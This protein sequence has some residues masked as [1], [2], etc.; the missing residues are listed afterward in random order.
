MLRMIMFGKPGAGKGTLSA[1]LVKKY[2]I[3]SIST[4]DLLRQHIAHKTDIGKQAEEIV[5][6]GDLLPD[7]LVLR[8]VTSKLDHLQDKHWILD[9]FPRTIGQGELL[10]AHLRLA[11]TPLTLLAT[12][13]VPLPF[14]RA[15]IAGRFVHAAS[16]RVYNLDFNPPRLAG[17]D[18]LT[19]EPLVQR[20]DD[21]PEVYERRLQAYER[22]TAPLLGYYTARAAS[23]SAGGMGGAGLRVVSFAGETSDEMWPALEQ[24]V[25]D[26]FPSVKVREEIAGGQAQ[27]R[28]LPGAKSSD[29]VAL[30]ATEPER[31]A[32]AAEKAVDTPFTKIKSRP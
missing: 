26:L 16:G 32:G 24:T 12:L 21:R 22:E 10:D 20:P 3:I 11:H 27:T 6:R 18:D 17:L 9:G 5:A 23:E 8:V 31:R 14:L 29:A 25:R 1:R 19:G 2:D 13:A 28:R 4:G 30:L 15:R 7:E